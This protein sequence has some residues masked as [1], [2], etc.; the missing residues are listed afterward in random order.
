MVERL[1]SF[2]EAI[3]KAKSLKSAG[4]QQVAVAGGAAEIALE[5]VDLL[6]PNG[7]RIVEAKHLVLAGGGKHR[8]LGSSGS[9]KSTLF[10]AISGIWP[11]G[12]GRILSPRAC[13]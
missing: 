8:C 3:D 6:L 10:R 12:D 9:G 7:R 11:Y 1:N 5:D 4:P 13:A 2:D